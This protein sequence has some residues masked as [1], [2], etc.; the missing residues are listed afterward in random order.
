M[1]ITTGTPKRVPLWRLV[2]ASVMDAATYHRQRP[3]KIENTVKV[4]KSLVEC[5]A[6]DCTMECRCYISGITHTCPSRVNARG[7]SLAR[8]FGMRHGAEHSMDKHNSTDTSATAQRAVASGPLV[9]HPG[10]SCCESCGTWP[11][12]KTPNGLRCH[13]CESREWAAA[14]PVP[15]PSNP[16]MLR[17]LASI[18]VAGAA[19]KAA[20]TSMTERRAPDSAQPNGA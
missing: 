12:A 10:P 4:L 9:S 15:L 19:E 13:L 3:S 14:H 16:D 18:G 11:A 20:N 7:L 8:T 17:D 6:V 5:T 2:L 1:M